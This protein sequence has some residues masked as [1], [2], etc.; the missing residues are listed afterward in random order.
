VKRLSLSIL[1]DHTLRYDQGK[2][3]VEAPTP[4]KL[5]VVKDLVA[6]AVG[7]DIKRGD[8]LVVEAF[9]FESTLAAQPLTIEPS[10][11]G[12][13]PS[14]LPLIFRRFTIITWTGTNGTPL[15][16]RAATSQLLWG[17]ATTTTPCG[18]T[19]SSS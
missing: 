16:A 6:A 13:P 5:Q 14:A 19:T 2:P 7:V 10:A 8:L 18:S 15:T 12:G 9:P 11:K 17:S 3:V 1:V 4:E